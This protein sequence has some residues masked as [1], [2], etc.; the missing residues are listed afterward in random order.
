MATRRERVILDLQDDFTPGMAKVA[1]AAAL[2]NQQL[3]RLS[4]REVTASRSTSVFVRDVE[5][6]NRESRGAERQI[7]RL[8]GRL[9]LLA[10]A[11][12]IV[13]PAAAPITAVAVPAITGLAAQLG[14][15][16]TA[17]AGFVVAVQGIGDALGALAKARLEPTTENL[18]A[19]R[20][21]LEKLSPAG[22]D[23][24]RQLFGLRDEWRRLRDV[25]QEALF[26]GLSS[27]L[28]DM[29]TRL[30]DVERLLVN[31]NTAVGEMLAGGA[32][33]LSSSRWDDFFTFIATD[34]PPALAGMASALGNVA[35]AMSELWMAFD[36]LNDDF[37][38]WL[39]DS[40]AS[41]DRWAQGLSQTEGFQAFVDY[42]R[43][44]GP[45]VAETLGAI[46]LAVIRIGEAAAPLGGPVLSALEAVAEAI[47]T[48]AGSDAG[49]A[50][51]ATV[52]ALALLRRGMATFEAVQR[53][54][55]ALVLSSADT[56]SQRVLA[57]RSPLL[58]TSAALA[59][60]ALASSDAAQGF[61]LANTASGALLGMMGGPWGA[62][63]GGAVGLMLDLSRST[64]GFKVN[65][66]SL[67]STLNQQTG[68][69]T[70]NTSAYAA[71]ELERQGVLRAAQDL[72]LS[73]SDV[74]Q[75][76]LGN[77]DALARV[78]GALAATRDGFYDANGRITVS[79]DKFL[80]F[81]ESSGLVTDAIGQMSGELAN[82]QTR[83]GRMADATDAGTAA[84]RRGATAAQD[85]ADAVTKL[86]NVLSGRASLRDY[87]AA[88][89]DFAKS[90]R[91]NG[92][93]FDIATEK[94]RA[95]QAALDNIAS[96]A[97]RVAE[98]MRGAARQRFLT[99]AIA[100]LRDMGNRF[101]VPKAQTQ[102]LIDLLRKANET[103]V[104][105]TI[106]ADT[107]SAMSNIE[108]VRAALASVR[109]KTVTIRVTQ[110]GAAVTPGFGPVGS[111]DGSTVPKTG[112][113]YADRHLYL[114][115]DGEEVISNRRGQADRHRAL[116]KAINAGMAGGGT[117]GWTDRWPDSGGKG[118]R[119]PNWTDENGSQAVAVGGKN[120]LQQLIRQLGGLT[121]AIERTEK[122]ITRQEKAVDK[123]TAA[124]DQ[125]T[126]SRDAV[127]G[128]MSALGAATTAGFQTSLFEAREIPGAPGSSNIW[129]PGAFGPTGPTKA[130]G[131]LE[132][133]SKD[134]SG[135]QERSALQSQLA[136]AGLDGAAF[137]AA[138]SQGS[139][140]DLASLLASG[141]VE[142]FEAM[143][144]Q[145]EALTASVGGQAGQ[146]RYGS[147]LSASEAAL[148]E[149][150]SLLADVKAELKELKA[151]Q[152]L[153]AQ[154][155]RQ[156][157][158]QREKREERNADRTGDRVAAAVGGATAAAGRNNPRPRVGRP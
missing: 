67:T 114:L 30:P 70:A 124:V 47:G 38:T 76:S 3:E 116:L 93:S 144:A 128:Q 45:Q 39:V 5:R 95:N 37:A 113:P 57:A 123:Q 59:G 145:R 72:G 41:L 87:E 132:N 118:G 12:A 154:E 156:R 104:N 84:Y 65:A 1:A 16:A 98:N 107:S 49:P 11:V 31:V 126:Q 147:A 119:G 102:V 148:A 68:A 130:G 52:T 48:L 88:V 140:A 6:L 56:F 99:A 86:N 91:E 134:I 141:Q 129:A 133:L 151:E 69:I 101:G 78:N 27:A 131:W 34:A 100:D 108:R 22:Q 82:G 19:A 103:R 4:G 35:H 150:V 153:L 13:G 81:G 97:I 127:L 142:Q 18:A 152:R 138:I 66:E 143:F 10:D 85:F 120:W 135:L 106:T 63:V 83:I 75:A 54:S 29:E 74:T 14:F 60:V 20:L 96:T 40:T 8:S 137:E 2:L 111:A 92:R 36:P 17:G 28:D 117:T 125:A 26:P 21:E 155:E 121:K 64:D 158:R 139:N 115:A 33:S 71:Q 110:T 157:E 149:Q 32:E 55:W 15:A 50:I 80:D 24:T 62:V 77:A 122:A 7:D 136:L 94:G 79:T 90:L 9:G 58:R 23:L 109:D 46:A 51:M 53:T 42:V 25:S 61:G 43:E 73:L 89:D 146:I 105:P 44:S 112:L